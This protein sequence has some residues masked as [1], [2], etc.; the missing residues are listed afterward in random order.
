MNIN[1]TNREI[2]NE[3]TEQYLEEARGK[4]IADPMRAKLMGMEDIRGLKGTMTPR[5]FATKVMRY[6]QRNHPNTDLDQLSD[7]DLQKAINIVSMTSKPLMGKERK[8]T[9]RPVGSAEKDLKKG[10][11]GYETLFLNL[12]DDAT[13]SH[14]GDVGGNE[15]YSVESGG[16]KYRVTL[17][18]FVGTK[19]NLNDIDKDNVV[20][21][22]IVKPR[23]YETVDKLA[24]EIDIGQREKLVADFP[25]GEEDDDDDYTPAEAPAEDQMGEMEPF[26]DE[27]EYEAGEMEEDEDSETLMQIRKHISAGKD[28]DDI[29]TSLGLSDHPASVKYIQSLVKRYKA[30]QPAYTED[31]KFVGDED[32]EF[33]K[34]KSDLNKDGKISEYERARGEAIAK[35]MEK[36]KQK[37][38][39]D[40]DEVE[41]EDNQEIALSPQQIN[42]LMLQ[43]RRANLQHHYNT[44]QRYHRF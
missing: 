41:E 28:A 24:G 18:D 26:N 30:G 23:E 25:E 5:Y 37:D 20:S 6:L 29:I 9:T 3:N 17:K 22:V 31:G 42:Q 19:L 7:E 36:S 15:L 1:W 8:V 2:L 4:K 21:V 13:L 12:D 44:E 16:L 35:A 14:D 43:Q 38:D 40:E 32:D 33:D 34:E 27:G 10:D 39:K 11:S